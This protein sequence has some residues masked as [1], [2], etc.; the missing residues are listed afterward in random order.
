MLGR[1]RG[2]ERGSR[3]WK[4]K[5]AETKDEMFWAVGNRLLGSFLARARTSMPRVH[6]ARSAALG[7]LCHIIIVARMADSTPQQEYVHDLMTLRPWIEGLR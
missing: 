6:P 7:S 5:N 4:G 2:M 3:K 1:K